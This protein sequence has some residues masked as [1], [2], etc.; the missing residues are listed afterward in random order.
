M[1]R[2]SKA[3]GACSRS[4]RP[5]KKDK[6]F[7]EAWEAVAYIPLQ[8]RWGDT[9]Y[10]QLSADELELLAGFL[11]ENAEIVAGIHALTQPG[12]PACDF[13]AYK[14]TNLHWEFDALL[15]ANMLLNTANGN[16]ED[17]A[18][19]LTAL[20][21]MCD[22]DAYIDYP[23]RMAQGTEH[24]LRDAITGGNATDAVWQAL[25]DQLE[26]SREHRIFVDDWTRA[27]GHWLEWYE[28]LPA[29][30]SDVTNSAVIGEVLG[31]G[32]RYAGTPLLNYN[33]DTFSDV[34][35][36]LLEV[37][38]LPYYQARPT[39]ERIRDDYSIPVPWELPPWQS[40]PGI[41]HIS[42]L[43]HERFFGR[44]YVEAHIDMAR[45]AILLQRHRAQFGAYPE[46]LEAV[47][48]GF[49]GTLP[50]NPLTGEPFRYER[51]ADT[52]RL[53]CFDDYVDDNG[54]NHIGMSI[55]PGEWEDLGP[56][57]P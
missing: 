48:E 41:W 19:D 2:S 5:K 34:M 33:M 38:P 12:M 45:M 11:G 1:P 4:G 7:A 52:F 22:A 55:W 57:A 46:T 27:A 3:G 54:V 18:R 15:S 13:G 49:G 43:I 6:A 21:K 56:K 26:E 28:D 29:S 37:A 44:A 50:A 47:A 42:T 20:L 10:D 25:L 32:Y 40:E 30:G 16:F 14:D 36:Q 35:A 24:C 39:I 23:F 53:W 51:Q 8:V 17:V 31:W 9:A